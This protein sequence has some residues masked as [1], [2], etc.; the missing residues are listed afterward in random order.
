MKPRFLAILLLLAA[1]LPAQTEWSGTVRDDAGRAAF[2][3]NVFPKQTPSRG[4]ITD[5]EGH[6]R[7]TELDPHDTL[8]ISYLGYETVE[9]PLADWPE[10]GRLEVQL[11]T[12]AA[13]LPSI[14]IQAS[15]PI[16]EQFSVVVLEKL[17]IYLN[18]VAQGDPLKAI[19]VLP[20]ST[21]T[22]ESANPSLRGS[23]ADRSR[24]VLNGVPIYQPVRASQLN[25]Q[26]FFSLF[27]PEI[28]DCQ[29]VYASNP[30]L[31]YGN[32]SAGLVDIKTHHQLEREQVQVSTSLA[33][34]GAFLARQLGP[35]GSFVQLYGNWQFA[36]A[37]LGLNRPNLP[38]LRDFHTRDVG[39]NLHL[40]LGEKS[41]F[42]SYHYA[43]D[44]G[45]TYHN[46]RP[47]YDGPAESTRQR[48]FVVN[49]W[50]RRTENGV[51]TAQHA[52]NFSKSAFAYGNLHSRNR[53]RQSYTALNYQWFLGED[54]KWQFGSSVDWHQQTFRD[55]FPRYYYAFAPEAPRDFAQRR[56]GHHNWEAYAYTQW[57]AGKRYLL[58][59]GWRS[60]VPGGGQS[61][62]Q[63]WQVAVKFFWTDQQSLLLSGGRYHN[64]ANPNY[65][66]PGF[67][68]QSSQQWSLDYS[69]EGTQWLIRA[70]LYHKREDSEANDFGFF[71]V[72]PTTTS[73]VEIFW[74][75]ELLP[76]L[77]WTLANA[78][79]HQRV[80]LAGDKYRGP[81]DFNYLL[82]TTLQ[83]RH[84]QL[85]TTALSWLSRPGTFYTPIV[86]GQLHPEVGYFEP[87][88][89]DRY[90]SEQLGPY[91]RLDLNVSRYFRFETWALT[92][93]LS[94]NNLLNTRNQR[95]VL[96]RADYRSYD[97][98][99]YQLRSIY[100]GLVWQWNR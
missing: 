45:Y 58:S 51:W 6:F 71:S 35:S 28:I 18:P 4:V 63:S 32:T 7:L 22:D 65:F 31:T 80:E 17:D 13:L 67:T 52:W 23:A 41:S 69:W 10:S 97:F 91:H 39:L 76:R 1:Q 44:E 72:G 46:T 53:T 27:N 61:F 49:N 48:Y 40:A 29:Y 16:S 62:Y 66:S 21:T 95:E 55:S 25:N 50:E 42:N 98:D 94:V 26:G 88:Y 20:S 12:S 83:Y 8:V 74:E 9:W 56:L 54:W 30:P 24:V 37:Y 73:G 36:P 77:R 99:Y 70:A 64:Y 60:N 87:Q 11:R 75:R 86:G 59:A 33:N 34:L 82:K 92:T 57:R 43:I 79:V 89:S 38:R 81:S 5:W 68:L 15:D 100:F 85:F 47:S 2:A 84:P 78:F 14:L 93:F 96:Y 3:A 90:Y 19:T